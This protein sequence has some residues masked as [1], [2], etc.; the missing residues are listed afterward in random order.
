MRTDAP[1]LAEPSSSTPREAW[2]EMYRSYGSGTCSLDLLWMG[3]ELTVS[4]GTRSGRRR[5]EVRLWE[6]SG[7][8]LVWSGDPCSWD[9]LCGRIREAVRLSVVRSVLE[10]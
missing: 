1:V 9:G 6:G 10:D 8:F 3:V 4:L 5:V 7:T 2:E